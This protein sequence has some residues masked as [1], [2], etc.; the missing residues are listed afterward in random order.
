MKKYYL[1]LFLV[2]ALVL[3]SCSS[4]D[5]GI[6]P[7]ELSNIQ[8][9]E[10]PGGIYLQWDLPDEVETVK[11]IKVSYF[12]LLEQRDMVRLS[13]CDTILIPNTLQRLGEYTFKVQPFS[14]DDVAGKELVVK[15]N[16][17]RAPQSFISTPITLK[18]AQLSTNAQESSGGPIK[19]I[20]DGN[21]DTFFHTSWT[22]SIPGPHWMQVDLLEEITSYKFFY[23]PRKNGANKPTDF[24]LLGSMDGNDW[25][26]IKNYTKEADGLPTTSSDSYKSEINTSDKP[27]RYIRYS[28]NKTN[29]NSVFW[30]MTVFK[31][32][33]VDIV[34]PE[35]E[36]ESDKS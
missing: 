17:G 23:S 8:A 30:T 26:L 13:S 19:N 24:D 9:E 35:A 5:D 25:F 6:I 21:M 14:N 3:A 27:F 12:D 15:A 2:F 4:D 18:E 22:V 10:R 32:Y 36:K 20:L 1:N 11:Y 34:D 7:G 28:V 33:K 16:S 29:T 31:F